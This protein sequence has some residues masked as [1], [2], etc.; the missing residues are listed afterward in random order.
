ML[1][2]G[3]IGF[4]GFFESIGRAQAA[5]RLMQMGQLEAAKHLMLEGAKK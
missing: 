3:F 1:L 2:K 4:V 5:S